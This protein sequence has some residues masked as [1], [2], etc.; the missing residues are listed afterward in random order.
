MATALQIAGY[1][2]NAGWTGQDLVV[3]VAVALAESGGDP[4]KRGDTSLQTS[5]WGPSIGLWQIRSLNAEKGHG[6][7]R[8]EIANLDPQTNANHAYSIWKS[9]GWGPWSAHNNRTYLLYMPV[10][11]AGASDY[12]TVN[13]G[14]AAG[15]TVDAVT[16]DAVKN[17]ADAA[18]QIAKEPVRV[19]EWL[20]QQG[21]QIRI[22]K[23]IVG[24]GLV[25]VGLYI[26]AR[27]VVQPAINAGAKV[28]KVAAL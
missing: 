7:T 21:T 14:K 10:A 15:D 25:V 8:D 22:G 4:K 1:A 24:G 27:P 12:Y 28:G 16:P 20:T 17:A 13:P 18:L 5:E 6:T 2:H 9:Q 23:V 11:S 19:L 26:F 3:A